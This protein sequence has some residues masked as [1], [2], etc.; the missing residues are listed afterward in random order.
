MSQDLFSKYL[1]KLEVEVDGEKL[2]LDVRLKDK[3]RLMAIISRCKDKI[4]EKDLEELGSLFKEI[5]QRSYPNESPE[6][7]EAFLA[8]KFESFLEGL[9]IAFGWATKKEIEERLKKKEEE[10]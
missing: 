2:E 4:E 9:T 3:H 1:G 6:A 7:I 5:L 10:A 8:K